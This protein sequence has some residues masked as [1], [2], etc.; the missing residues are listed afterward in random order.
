MGDTNTARLFWYVLCNYICQHIP[1]GQT[2][3]DVYPAC[4]DRYSASKIGNKYRPTNT[5]TTPWRS[6]AIRSNS[7]KDNDFNKCCSIESIWNNIYDQFYGFPPFTRWDVRWNV[8]E[9]RYTT[10][11]MLTI[12]MFALSVTIEMCVTLTR[13]LE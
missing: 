8:I 3:R 6:Y 12:V 10:F 2:F 4:P 1:Q 11:C 7:A 5:R 9:S 13:H